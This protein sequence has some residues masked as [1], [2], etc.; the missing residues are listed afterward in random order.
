MVLGRMDRVLGREDEQQQG[1]QEGAERRHVP[2][3]PAFHV[4]LGQ[5]CRA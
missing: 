5:H 1:H 4:V 3:D 2:H